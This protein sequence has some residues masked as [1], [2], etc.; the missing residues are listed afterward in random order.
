MGTCFKSKIKKMRKVF[1][2]TQRQRTKAINEV[3]FK[4]QI[5]FGRIGLS[6]FEW[7]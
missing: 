5:L 4:Y 7:V 2:M 3:Q 1:R 6:F